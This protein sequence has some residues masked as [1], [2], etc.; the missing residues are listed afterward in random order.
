M[1]ILGITGG[2]ATGK[3]TVTRMFADLG[4]PTASADNIARELLGRPDIHESLKSAF[5]G[6]V[7]PVSYPLGHPLYDGPAD[8]VGQ[9]I[10]TPKID[11]EALRRLIFSNKKARKRLEAIT[12]PPIVAELERLIA[13]FRASSTPAAAAVEI[14]LLFEAGLTGMVDRIVVVA[15]DEET[16]ISRLR[17]RL[18]ITRKEALQQL[19]AQLP[20]AQKVAAADFVIDSGIDIESMRAQVLSVW[21]ALSNTDPRS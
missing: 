1:I 16:Q 4:A 13:E 15:C 14:P 2:I 10:P 11:I 5:P 12:H 18:G 8:G 9:Y 19:A 20:L 17:T 21:N 7:G 6:C 3:S